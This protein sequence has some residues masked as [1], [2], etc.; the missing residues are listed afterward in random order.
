MAD[1]AKIAKL[2]EPPVRKWLATKYGGGPYRERKLVLVTGKKVSFDA[3]SADGSVVAS[4]LSNRALTGTGHVNSGGLHKAET[5]F[6]RLANIKDKKVRHRLMVFTD[7]DFRDSV[8]RRL[9]NPGALH[10]ETEFFELQA[11][12]RKEIERVLDAARAE[13][14][15]RND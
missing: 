11:P 13:Q 14:R 5:D 12:V 9:G 10:V 6:W 1:T 7:R 4:I 2:V 15:S 8:E 3:V